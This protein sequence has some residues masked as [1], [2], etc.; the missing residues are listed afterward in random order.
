MAHRFQL[1]VLYHACHR[2]CVRRVSAATACLWLAH[3]TRHG[4]EDVQRALLRYT[5]RH[6]KAIG[7]QHPESLGALREFPD[8]LAEI[9]LELSR[10]IPG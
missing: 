10:V 2:E 3:S 7:Q 8:V 4:L 6:W 1:L 5:V 9:L